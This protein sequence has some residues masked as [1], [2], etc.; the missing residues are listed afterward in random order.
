MKRLTPIAAG[1]TCVLLVL[2]FVFILAG[3]VEHARSEGERLSIRDLRPNEEVVFSI[4][5]AH[6]TAHARE[7]RIRSEGGRRTVTIF[8]TT[9]EWAREVHGAGEPVLFMREL[10]TAEI[11]GLE[12]TIAYCRE[13]REEESSATRQM[14]L[15]YLRDGKQIGE[16]FYIGFSLPSQLA[17]YDR[18]GMRGDSDYIYDYARLAKQY[19]ISLQRIHRMISFEMLEKNEPNQAPEPTS[20]AVTPRADARVAPA[21]AAARL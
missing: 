18:Q 17:Y 15:R 21:A 7:Y 1:F 8:D 3:D 14:R 9:P 13:I 12:E 6:R 11:E 10:S 20:T 2:A 5:V 4:L 16:E 19:G